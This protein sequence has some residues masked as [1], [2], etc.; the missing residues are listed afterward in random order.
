MGPSLPFLRLQ[1]TT[2]KMGLQYYITYHVYIH[3]KSTLHVCMYV[4]MTAFV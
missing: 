3:V 4:Y 1:V 2:R